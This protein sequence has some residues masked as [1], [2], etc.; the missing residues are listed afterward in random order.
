MVLPIR[1]HKNIMEQ[2]CQGSW[3]SCLPPVFRAAALPK[4][5]KL[6]I[7]MALNGSHGAV[8]GVRSLAEQ[9]INAGATKEEITE[10][11]RSAQYI[12][13][14]GCVYAAARTFKDLFVPGTFDLTDTVKVSRIITTPTSLYWRP[15]A[16]IEDYVLK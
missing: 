8:E 10:T 15:Y 2:N 12:R 16:G 6:L 14:V 7:A 9:A 11:I 1:Y 4:K 3:T 13:G 5:F